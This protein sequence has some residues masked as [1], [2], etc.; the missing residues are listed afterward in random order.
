MQLHDKAEVLPS[1]K[2]KVVVSYT[3]VSMFVRPLVDAVLNMN[4]KKSVEIVKN[5]HTWFCSEKVLSIN[6]SRLKVTPM[7]YK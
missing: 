7:K 3:V 4:I 5:I 1:V 2:L 6:L